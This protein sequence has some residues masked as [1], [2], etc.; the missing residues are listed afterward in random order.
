M[1]KHTVK[2]TSIPTAC[3][4]VKYESIACYYCVT[5]RRDEKNANVP[6]SFPHV[7]KCGEFHVFSFIHNGCF[8]C[9]S[10]FQISELYLLCKQ[11]SAN[12]S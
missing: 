10:R 9:H 7:K 8:R 1:E 2:R 12:G 11:T 3:I 5:E 4:Q 6:G